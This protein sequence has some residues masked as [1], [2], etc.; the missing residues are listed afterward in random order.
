MSGL[1]LQHPWLF[2]ATVATAVAAHAFNGQHA[3]NTV[4]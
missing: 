3:N 4:A 1:S 2:A